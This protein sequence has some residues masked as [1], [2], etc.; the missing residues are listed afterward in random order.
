MS[1]RI[2]AHDGNSQQASSLA[3]NANRVWP[4]MTCRIPSNCPCAESA[5]PRTFHSHASLSFQY[6]PKTPSPLQMRSPASPAQMLF[7]CQQSNC[8]AKG[9]PNLPSGFTSW[10][11]WLVKH[12]AKTSRE[13]KHA[14]LHQHMTML[15]MNSSGRHALSLALSHI[16]KTLMQPSCGNGPSTNGVPCHPSMDKP[17]SQPWPI[18][19]ECLKYHQGTGKT[20]ATVL[21]N[22][23]CTKTCWVRSSG[24]VQ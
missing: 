19:H 8:R 3:D 5:I 2:S 22:C 17:C 13:V 11:C 14:C 18:H 16:M 9:N 7:T 10:S 15:Y 6:H 1:D 20:H 23:S 12:S 24:A 4:D 21:E